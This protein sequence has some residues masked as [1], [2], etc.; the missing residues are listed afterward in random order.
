MPE[1]G[2]RAEV[3]CFPAVHL[4]PSL[5]VDLKHSGKLS[6]ITARVKAPHL[7]WGACF[8]RLSLCRRRCQSPFVF[9]MAQHTRRNLIKNGLRYKYFMPPLMTLIPMSTSQHSYTI[10]SSGAL[11]NS[12]YTTYLF[13]G[14]TRRGLPSLPLGALLK[15]YSSARYYWKRVRGV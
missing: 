11:L 13:E 3:Q 5:L 12:I 7:W 14:G 6:G 15:F 9:L 10:W 4:S 8:W 2:N 1:S